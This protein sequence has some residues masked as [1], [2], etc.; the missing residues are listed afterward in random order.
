MFHAW[1]SLRPNFG[2]ELWRFSN[3]AGLLNP[4]ADPQELAL[5]VR[6]G[7]TTYNREKK[8]E[9]LPLIRV[10]PERFASANRALR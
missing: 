6:L 3:P 5:Y 2:F 10:H 4:V 9:A 1:V 7:E 8:T